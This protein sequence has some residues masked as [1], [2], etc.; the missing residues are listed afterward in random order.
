MIEAINGETRH[1]ISLPKY[2]RYYVTSFAS[3]ISLVGI[4]YPSS[5]SFC[6]DQWRK[7]SV[8]LHQLCAIARDHETRS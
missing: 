2:A 5:Q 6:R 8:S 7:L 1:A 3:A 4:E